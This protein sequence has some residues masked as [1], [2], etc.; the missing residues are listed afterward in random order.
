MEELTLEQKVDKLL[1]TTTKIDDVICGNPKYKIMGL[2]ER[3]AEDERRL[4]ELEFDVGKMRQELNDKKLKE[5]TTLLTFKKVLYVML[6]LLTG[7]L[8][9]KGAL[10]WEKLF[11]ILK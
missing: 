6:I 9:I 4:R 8:I 2:I 5:D 7:F 3:Q 1:M 11:D 10:D